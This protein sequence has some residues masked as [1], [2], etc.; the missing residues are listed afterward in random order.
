M[1]DLALELSSIAVRLPSGVTALAERR[2]DLGERLRLWSAWDA[3]TGS[4]RFFRVEQS[5]EGWP[6]AEDVTDEVAPGLAAAVE[7]AER[8]SRRV[9]QQRR[10]STRA[11]TAM[12]PIDWQRSRMDLV[13]IETAAAGVKR[14][15]AQPP[16]ERYAARKIVTA[17]QC[18]A[19]RKLYADH[20]FGIIGARDEDGE[21]A[22]GIRAGAA[23][24][25]ADV[26]IA[27]ATAFR[28]AMVA[29][30]PRLSPLVLAVCVEDQ[31]LRDIAG[32]TG[33]NGQ[34]LTALLTTALD[35]L[36]DHYKFP[37]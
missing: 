17:R 15:Y 6:I 36:A 18:E 2:P 37:A 24:G 4:C 31:T 3:A 9:A 7:M 30:G 14:R 21:K 10:Q 22:P 27:A 34:A 19:G 5:A 29:L 35:V 16:L 8:A 33:Q 12:E 20:A 23:A 11:A 1:M 25:Y 13:E 26:R 32:R 28:L